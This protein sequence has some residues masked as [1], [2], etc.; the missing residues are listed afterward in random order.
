MYGILGHLQR[1]PAPPGGA[2]ETFRNKCRQREVGER[3]KQDTNSTS[4]IIEDETHQE[5][6]R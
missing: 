2:P 6:Y 5:T 3:Y 4:V 1:L